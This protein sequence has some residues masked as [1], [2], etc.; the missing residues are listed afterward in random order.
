MKGFGSGKKC[1]QRNII[2]L[3]PGTLAVPD[4]LHGE[5]TINVNTHTRT[6]TWWNSEMANDKLSTKKAYTVCRV[7]AE[8]IL[9]IF[10]KNEGI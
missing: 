1:L 9:R 2:G 3:F 6:K 7:E 8:D 4:S 10:L 5:W